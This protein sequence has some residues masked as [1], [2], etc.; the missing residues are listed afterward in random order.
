MPRPGSPSWNGVF[1]TFD[2]LLARLNW[3]IEEAARLGPALPVALVFGMAL[4]EAIFLPRRLW[5]RGVA[6]LVVLL[7]GFGA[8]ALLRW[9]QRASQGGAA[10]RLAAERVAETSALEG[11]WAQWD[12]LSHTLPATSNESPAKFDT[13]DDALASLSAKVASIGDQI[14]TLKA[15]AV[16]RSIGPATADKLAD[17]L[18]QYGSYRVVVSCAPDDIE[19]YSYANQLVGIL[20]A[21]GWDANGPEATANVLDQGAMGVM[22][23]IRDQSA[24][25]AAKILL[26]AFNQ[27]NIPHQPG[28]SADDAIPDTATVELF[29]AKKP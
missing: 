11:L 14:T 6:V 13:V 27:M 21:A 12:M 29:V 16:G 15:G 8:F 23:L 18:R 7:F 17:Y 26:D 19:A 22:V 28:I 10:D 5:A 1:P 20:R 24:P 25:D 2:L 3:V 9:E 4:I